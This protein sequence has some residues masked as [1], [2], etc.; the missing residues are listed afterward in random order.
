MVWRFHDRSKTELIQGFFFFL[1]I[2]PDSVAD[3]VLG[4]LEGE[5]ERY[6]KDGMTEQRRQVEVKRQEDRQT[7]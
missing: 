3:C 2:Q 6:N 5:G 1:I 7:C 4:R